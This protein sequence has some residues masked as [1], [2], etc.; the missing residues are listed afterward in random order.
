MGE[1]QA[2]MRRPDLLRRAIVVVALIGAAAVL[3]VIGAASFKPKQ[4]ADLADLRRGS[5]VKLVIPDD[6]APAPNVPFTDE[7]GQPVTLA[8]F[9]G[10]VVVVNLWA[11]WCAPCKVEM[12]TLAKLQATY[13]TQPLQ[14]VAITVDK[15]HDMNLVRQELAANQPLKLYRDPA[16]KVAFGLQPRAKGFPT[17]IVYDRKGVER[18]RLSGA[19][20]WASPEARELVERLLREG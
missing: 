9:K 12:P 14:V 3:Y 18:A 19:A 10:Q 8:D 7:K 17:T 4:S 6:P 20:D 2:G 1:V 5:L 15:D 16:Y 11:T 13:A